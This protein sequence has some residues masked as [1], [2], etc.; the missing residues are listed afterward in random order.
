MERLGKEME[1]KK[2]KKVKLR[3]ETKWKDSKH[4]EKIESLFC[5]SFYIVSRRKLCST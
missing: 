1:A 3:F 4:I 5:G 2:L